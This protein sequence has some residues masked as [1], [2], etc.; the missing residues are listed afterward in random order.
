MFVHD[1]GSED[2][3]NLRLRSAKPLRPIPG[4]ERIEMTVSCRDT[5]VLPKVSGAGGILEHSS[6]ERCQKMHNG[7]NV[8]ASAYHGEWMS[9]VIRRLHGHHEP[10]EELLFDFA[11]RNLGGNPSEMTMIEAGAFWAYYSL[12]FRQL[13]PA[14]RSI[15]LEPDPHNLEVGR[16]NFNLNGFHGDFFANGIG[17]HGCAIDFISE[18]DGKQRTLTTVSID[19]LMRDLSLPHITVLHADIQGAELALLRGAIQTIKSGKIQWLFLSTHHH[20]ISG[21]PLTHQRCLH[22]LT[23]HGAQIIDEHSVSES[24]SGDGLI[25]A[26]FGAAV[27]FRSPAIS[28]NLPSRSLFREL[29]YDLDQAWMEIAELRRRLQTVER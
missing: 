22:F 11:L 17:E 10:Q 9:E 21:D 15:L 27:P 25:V 29:E 6:G 1:S 13:H 4:W 23:D 8:L 14:A 7:I 16:R 18:S 19:G 26:H 12:W 28:R 20:S 2:P 5:E 24:F 3:T